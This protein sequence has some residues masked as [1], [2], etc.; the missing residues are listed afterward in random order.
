MGQSLCVC[1]S[2]PKPSRDSTDELKLPSDPL[3]NDVTDVP[4]STYKTMRTPSPLINPIE[5]IP[6]LKLDKE[7]IT[8][9]L[10]QACNKF[11]DLAKNELSDDGCE[12][13]SNK[14]DF[15]I[16]SGDLGSAGSLLKCRWIFPYDSQVFLEYLL[17]DNLRKKWE[18]SISELNKVCDVSSDTFIS[19]ILYK[20]ILA[21]AP[22][23]LLIATKIMRMGESWV[24]VNTSVDLESYPEKE[25]IVRSKVLVSGYF[26][27][28]L[29]SGSNIQTLVTQISLGDYGLGSAMKNLFRNF[30]ATNI[31]KYGRA[32]VRM[33][34]REVESKV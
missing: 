15:K 12:C 34:R 25:G 5:Q 23:D 32:F 30:T 11:I 33:V 19:Y 27:E 3:A 1:V 4:I 8:T 10:S 20:R 31:P 14:E 26:L 7:C 22:R 17:K 29:L 18:T 24:V 28:P 13:I 9:L 2:N 16:Y 21:V 6:S